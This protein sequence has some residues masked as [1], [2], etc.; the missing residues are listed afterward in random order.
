[1]KYSLAMQQHFAMTCSRIL[2]QSIRS[3]LI[4]SVVPLQQSTAH[5]SLPGYKWKAVKRMLAHKRTGAPGGEAED[6][7]KLSVADMARQLINLNR[8]DRAEKASAEVVE[9]RLKVNPKP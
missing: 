9:V 2:I 8:A 6:G 5:S 3:G 7:E 1:M 4:C